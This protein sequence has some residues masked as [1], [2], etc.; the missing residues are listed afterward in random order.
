MFN[1]GGNL[2][3]VLLLIVLDDLDALVVAAV[4]SHAVSQLHLMALGALDD[5]GQGQLPVGLAAVLASLRNFSLRKS[6][7]HTSSC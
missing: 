4:L 5:A 3:G 7:I 2:S 1:S 6:H